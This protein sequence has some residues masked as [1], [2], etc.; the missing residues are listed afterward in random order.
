VAF[1]QLDVVRI[2]TT[3]E[4]ASGQG[5]GWLTTALVYERARGAAAA[6]VEGTKLEREFDALFPPAGLAL[7]AVPGY[8]DLLC[9]QL[10]AWLAEVDAA[11]EARALSPELALVDEALADGGD[12]RGPVDAAG[13]W[14]APSSYRIRWSPRARRP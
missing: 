7:A 3:L 8:P 1:D 4:A 6:M 2:R 14:E 11:R 12:L 10:Q 13:D 5:D 9:R